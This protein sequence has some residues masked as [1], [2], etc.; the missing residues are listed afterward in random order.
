[1][2]RKHPAKE[3]LRR[4]WLDDSDPWAAR[5]GWSLTAERI[6]KEPAGLDLDALLERI[7]SELLEAP[8]EAQWTMNNSLAGIGIHHS[9]LRD[10]AMAIGEKLGVFRD[11]PTPKGCTSPFAPLWITEMVSR[12]ES[13]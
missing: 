13:A 5:A 2:L 7:E 3:E 6:G 10:R 1:M 8:P 4:A 11:Y 9:E 12:Q